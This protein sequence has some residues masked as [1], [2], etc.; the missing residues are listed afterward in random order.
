MRKEHFY[1]PSEDGKTTLHGI[2]WEPENGEIR[3]VLQLVHGMAEHI[4]RYHEFAI[5][6]TQQGFAVIG[7]DHLGHGQSLNDRKDMGF[8][9]KKDGDKI[10]LADIHRVTGYGKERFGEKPWFI[11]GHSMGSFMVRRYLTLHSDKLAGA[12]IM[13]TGQ[14]PGAVAGAGRMVAGLIKAIRGDHHRSK[15]LLAMSTGGYN[16]A[17]EPART[18]ADWL[19]RNEENCDR[20]VAD[21]LCGFTFTAGAYRDF[22][23]VIAQLADGSICRQVR[24]DIPILLNAG[25]N[26]PVGGAKDVPKVYEQYRTLG[27][28]DVTLKLYPEDR[29]EILN[30]VDRDTVFADICEWMVSKL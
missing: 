6:L 23:S 4:D 20:Y 13:G 17:F 21:E 9:A 16:K 24:R 12:I 27:V 26:D 1:I 19:S 5:Y 3:A 8:F 25:E 7:H 29:H 18:S 11:L 14:I 2:V 15:L 10:V 28:R 30:E 22:F